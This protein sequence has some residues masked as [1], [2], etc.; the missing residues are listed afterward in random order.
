M[1]YHQ[2]MDFFYFQDDWKLLPSLT[3]N[4]GLRYE[5][6]TPQFVDGNHLA[7]FDP[8]TNTLIQA[9]SGSLYKRALV[10]YAKTRFC[11]A[12]WFCISA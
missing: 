7:N 4:V 2:Y 3:V 10:Q 12:V 5:L 11:A 9:S 8:T 6:V 1:N